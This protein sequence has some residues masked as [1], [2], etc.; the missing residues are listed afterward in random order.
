ML[1]NITI[2]DITETFTVFSP[3]GRFEKINDRKTYGLSVCND[4]QTTYIHNGTK[5]ISDK[6]HAV[7]LPQGQSY[8][9]YGNKTGIFPVINF[10]CTELLCDTGIS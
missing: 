1:E 10:T 2:T 4:G 5:T 8:T 3:K 7:I 9:L 6:N